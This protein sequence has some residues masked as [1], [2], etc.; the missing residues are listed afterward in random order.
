MIN[1]RQVINTLVL[2]LVFPLRGRKST[3]FTAEA[4]HPP[5]PPEI[6]AQLTKTYVQSATRSPVTVGSRET[7]KT[8]VGKGCL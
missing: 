1:I 8:G 2:H 4:E 3:S 6:E 5:S 7:Y